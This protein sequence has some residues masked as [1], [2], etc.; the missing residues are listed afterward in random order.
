[1]R[2]IHT[3]SCKLHSNLYRTK[4]SV[5]VFLF[6]LLFVSV[7]LRLPYDSLSA[8]NMIIFTVS[9]LD[10]LGFT[11]YAEVSILKMV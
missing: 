5:F 9:E 8:L 11:T 6:Q 10:M 3:L 4:S 1:M 7:W 2:N